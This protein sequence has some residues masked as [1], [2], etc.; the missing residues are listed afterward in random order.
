MNNIWMDLTDALD[1]NMSITEMDKKYTN[2]YL[3]LITKSGE[4]RVVY[5]QGHHDGFHL[6]KDG[7]GVTIRLRQDTDHRVIC[8]FPERK[9][10][11]HN[12]MALEFTRLPNRQYRRGICKDNVKIYSP[13]RLMIN[14]DGHPWSYEIL[15]NALNSTYP[16]CCEEAIKEL[17]SETAISVALSEKFM[18][19]LSI[20]SKYNKRLHLFYMNKVIGYFEKD[21]FYIKHKVFQ[22]EVLDNIT[23]FKPYRIEF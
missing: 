7:D 9:L 2:T 21:T 23:I 6:F 20:E 10:F 13:I 17:Q 14:G 22:Q 3:L 8:S 12:G 19:S 4:E 1:N 5:Y 15:S 16:A 11:N 18:I